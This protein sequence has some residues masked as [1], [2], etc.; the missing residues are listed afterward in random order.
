MSGLRARQ[1]THTA[2]KMAAMPSS[3]GGQAWH[4]PSRLANER[5]GALLPYASAQLTDFRFRDP[6]R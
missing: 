2:P 3:T 4:V 6:V 1:N 5:C